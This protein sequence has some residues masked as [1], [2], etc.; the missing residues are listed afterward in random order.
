MGNCFHR[1]AVESVIRLGEALDA[2]A[3]AR[4]VDTAAE[5]KA[6]RDLGCLIG[7]GVP[8]GEPM[9][10]GA[11]LASANRKAVEPAAAP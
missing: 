10:E 4:G 3:T 5:A 1:V 9:T 11:F 7:Q 8:L 6:L 2:E